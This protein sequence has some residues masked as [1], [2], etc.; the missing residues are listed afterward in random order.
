MS[1]LDILTLVAAGYVLATSS[2]IVVAFLVDENRTKEIIESDFLTSVIV[3]LP[4]ILLAT[5][6]ITSIIGP[7][8]C[9]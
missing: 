7:A 4:N 2:L 8:P 9:K 1:I 5:Y 3:I 6:A